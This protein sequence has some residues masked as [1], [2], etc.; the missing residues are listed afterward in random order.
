M[1]TLSELLTSAAAVRNETAAD[2]NT[3]LR[4]GNVLYSLTSYLQQYTSVVDI[5]MK[6]SAVGV[7]ITAKSLSGDT[8]LFD[9]TI[10]LP[11]ASNNQAGILTAEAYS[12]IKA[13]IADLKEA[14]TDL[15]NEKE[16]IATRVNA[17]AE[18]IADLKEAFTDL[19]NEKEEIATRVN[20]N[21]ENIANLSRTLAAAKDEISDNAGK[22]SE[23][24]ASLQD[25]TE[26]ADTATRILTFSN[27]LEN[28]TIEQQG[29]AS[30]DSIAFVRGRGYFVAVKAGKYYNSFLGS[31]NYNAI[32][33][34]AMKAREDRLYRMLGTDAFYYFNGSAIRPLATSAS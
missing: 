19:F 33:G 5:T 22:I 24:S 30:Y 14:F 17:N 18:N 6:V 4:V 32:S 26:L 1:A 11:V 9:K 7:T 2:Q 15:F 3:A 20:A 10:A 16:E 25:T 23:L 31:D 8:T 28:A 29:V 27:I 34:G 21:A 13:D 12:A